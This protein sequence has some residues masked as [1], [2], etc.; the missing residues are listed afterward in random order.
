M[1]DLSAEFEIPEVS[2]NKKSIPKEK[3]SGNPPPPPPQML[4]VNASGVVTVATKMP[5]YDGPPI[6]FSKS[7]LDWIK[8]LSTA[9]KTISRNDLVSQIKKAKFKEITNNRVLE[10]LDFVYKKDL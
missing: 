7:E 5:K 1:K 8:K 10:L 9:R 3:K 4:S 2:I 6:P